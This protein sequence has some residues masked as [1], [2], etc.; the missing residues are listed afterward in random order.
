M[1]FSS[2]GFFFMNKAQMGPKII[3]NSLMK[4]LWWASQLKSA[5]PQYGRQP[6]QFSIADRIKLWDYDPRPSKLTF[7]I[8]SFVITFKIF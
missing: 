7:E 8:F 4:W 6:K 5:I 3:L 2:S 1:S